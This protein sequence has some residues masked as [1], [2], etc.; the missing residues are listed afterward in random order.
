MKQ[1]AKNVAAHL[2]NHNALIVN[3]YVNMSQLKLM[4]LA[5]LSTLMM[6][7]MRYQMVSVIDAAISLMLLFHRFAS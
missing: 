2:E 5:T 3:A 4:I 7:I 1:H 6:A